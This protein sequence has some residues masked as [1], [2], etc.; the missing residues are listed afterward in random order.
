MKEYKRLYRETHKNEIKKYKKEYRQKNAEEIREYMKDYMKN[1]QQKNADKLRESVKK[2]QQTPKGR[3]AMKVRNHNR[4]LLTKNLSVS[5]IQQ[6]YENNIKR[7]GTLTCYLCNKSIT[8]GQDS[9]EHTIPISKGGS[10]AI[11]N[12]NI[13]HRKCNFSKG[14]KTLEEYKQQSK[15]KGG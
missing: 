7:F 11:D 13:A 1:Y 5:I 3:L 6:V 12:L 4:R 14:K 2:Y 15:N 9:I 10:N 8:F